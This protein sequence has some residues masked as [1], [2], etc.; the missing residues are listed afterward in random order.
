MR[1]GVALLCG[2][3]FGAGLTL[4]GM[5]DPARVIGF[6]DMGGNWDPSLAIVMA[7][8]ITVA[9]PMFQWAVRKQP[10]P[11]LAARYYLP[12]RTAIDRDL[13]IGAVLFGLGWGIAGLCP[14]PA[15]AGLGSGRP[16][17]FAF[18]LA[19]AAGV[20]VRAMHAARMSYRQDCRS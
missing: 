5:T 2:T 10:R 11:L 7:S 13:A 16:E 4:A 1:A 8:A 3:L 9:L 12:E 15:I 19:M 14:G 20:G 6:L 18:V 17:I